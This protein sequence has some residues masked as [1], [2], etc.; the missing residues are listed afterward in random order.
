MEINPRIDCGEFSD[1]LG[2][3]FEQNHIHTALLHGGQFGFYDKL[4]LLGMRRYEL[5]LDSVLM[6]EPL[7]YDETGCWS[8]S[9]RSVPGFDVVNVVNHR[10]T[11]DVMRDARVVDFQ[12]SS[13]RRAQTENP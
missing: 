12:I 11:C 1:V 10:S 7:K 6:S 9:G 13:S 5:M 4:M 2:D 3:N 8:R